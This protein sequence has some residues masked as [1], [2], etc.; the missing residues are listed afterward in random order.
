MDGKYILTGL[1][2]VFM[3]LAFTPWI[4]GNDGAGYYSPVKS[5]V[6][7]GDLDLKDEYEHFS[8]GRSLTAVRKDENTGNYFSHYPIGS[9]LLWL[10]YVEL[11]HIIAPYLGYAQDGYSQIYVLFFCLGSAINAFFGLLMGYYV[12]KKFFP[13][14]VATLGIITVWLSS[15]LF[16]YM[17]FEPSLSHA[18]SM[19]TT[20]LV[21]FYWFVLKERWGMKGYVFGGAIFALAVLVRYQNI[22]FLWLP[23]IELFR[24]LK[25]GIWIQL[26]KHFF[27]AV[28]FVPLILMQIM[29][30][31]RTNGAFMPNYSG[32]FM[33]AN[34][35]INWY[36]VL[37]SWNH[38]LFTWTPIIFVCVLGLFFVNKKEKIAFILIFLSNL[39]ILS[40]W[41]AWNADQSFGHRMFINLFLIFAFG[42]CAVIIRI[43]K[44][45]DMKYLVLIS[46]LFVFWN[47]GLMVQYGSRMI[48]A[49]NAVPLEQIAYNNVIRVPKE[50]SKIVYKFMFNRGNYLG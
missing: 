26:K 16:Y 35:P 28:G 31:L 33:L 27:Y 17:F 2:I 38:G 25:T 7:D 22:I 46:L 50:L 19:F 13:D 29:I 40:G 23:I 30:L 1:F 42:L 44:T 18:H 37:V 39:F 32:G 4:H 43:S 12:L 21:L 24:E 9:A 34:V 45:V 5:L 10:P 14:K 15:S 49:E 6:I 20:S 47:F 3:A 36:K 8:K 11:A 41:S 48:S